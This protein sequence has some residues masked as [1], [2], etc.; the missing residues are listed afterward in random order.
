M[1]T[2]NSNDDKS[3]PRRRRGLLADELAKNAK[4]SRYK[5]KQA[6]AVAKYA[7][8]LM[9]F[10]TSGELKLR[11]AIDLMR[12]APEL[13]AYVVDGKLPCGECDRVIRELRQL[14]EPEMTFEE[15]VEHSYK[16]W[17]SRWPREDR[18]EV[19]D[20]VAWMPS[21]KLSDLIPSQEADALAVEIDLETSQ[22]KTRKETTK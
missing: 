15:E 6:I 3:K 21:A 19:H 5:A 9:P 22:T 20:I 14:T 8:E 17:L 11:Q 13:I 1:K 16:R 7:P 4:V 10:V 12:H 18:K 2:T